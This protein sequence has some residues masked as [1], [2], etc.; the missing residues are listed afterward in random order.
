[1]LGQPLHRRHRHQH[2]VLQDRI[3]TDNLHK[4]T[5]CPNFSDLE[6]EREEN[7]IADNQPCSSRPPAPQEVI[8]F[9]QPSEQ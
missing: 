9:L 2:S 4:A 8:S 5:K 7:L 1:M 6:H 3:D